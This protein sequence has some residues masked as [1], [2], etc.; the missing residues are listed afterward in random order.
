MPTFKTHFPVQEVPIGLAFFRSR[1]EE[2]LNS[3]SLMLEDVDAYYAILDENETILAGAG[4]YGD[5]IKCVAVSESERSSGLMVPLISHIVSLSG[6]RCLK[7]FTKPEYQL[8]FESLGFHL[9][10]SAPKAI[11]LENGRGLED[12]CSYLKACRGEG[13]ACAIGM[14]ANPLTLGH[15]DLV[16]RA[17]VEFD[18]VYVIAVREDVSLFSY[19]ERLT[20]MRGVLSSGKVSVLEGSSYQISAAT[21]PS[22]FLKDLSEASETQMRLDINLF[23]RWIAPALGV[24]VRLVGDEPYDALTARYNGLLAEMLPAYG[25]EARVL[26]RYC[27]GSEPVSASA[28]RKAVSLGDYRKASSMV[29]LKCRPYLLAVLASEALKTE[30]SLPLKPGLVGPEGSGAHKDMDAELMLRGIEAIRPFFPKM[31]MAADALSLQRLGIEAEEAMLSATGGVNT[32]RG[33]IFALGLALNAAWRVEGCGGQSAD[34]Q[35]LMQNALVEIAQGIVRNQ[36][37]DN[38]LGAT[39]LEAIPSHPDAT[40][41]PPAVKGAREMALGAYKELFED[42]LPFL[43]QSRQSYSAEEALQ[44]TLLRIMSTL[45]DTCILHRSGPARLKKVKAEALETLSASNFDNTLKELCRRY[46]SEGISPGGAADMLALTIFFD[47]LV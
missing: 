34:L 38:G 44:R 5:V 32:H 45:D 36:L 22:Y 18:R 24:S 33:A 12:Y 46:A 3:N 37:S 9:I 43:R 42:W 25:M 40:P 19:D 26:P 8:V 17:S 14:N 6:G 31:A 20:M 41:T 10:A 47:S 35:S 23:A 21:F 29:P 4:V 39:R 11:L 7:V 16:C 15:E 13:R 2:F 27:A 1:V 28:V 30:L